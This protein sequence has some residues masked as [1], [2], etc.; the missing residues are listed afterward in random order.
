MTKDAPEYLSRQDMAALPGGRVLITEVKDDDVYVTVIDATGERLPQEY[1]DKL[2]VTE[3]AGRAYHKLAVVGMVEWSA[4]PEALQTAGTGDSETTPD[5]APAEAPVDSA[6]ASDRASADG[7][8]EPGAGASYVPGVEDWL[9]DQFIAPEHVEVRHGAHGERDGVVLEP[10]NQSMSNGQYE[11]F[12]T[13]VNS[14]DGSQVHVGFGD[15]PC[16]TC[17]QS[18]GEFYY[19]L[20]RSVAPEVTG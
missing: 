6:E 18:D 15:D 7:T 11:S 16:Q 2:D 5:E 10:D 9:A 20:P 17:G 3:A 8:G 12:K 19:F 13:L 14:I 1:H 4:I